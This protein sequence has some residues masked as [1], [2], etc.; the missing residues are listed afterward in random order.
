MET[1]NAGRPLIDAWIARSG[2]SAEAWLAQLFRVVVIPFYHL[3][4]R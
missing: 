1:D 2:L 3:L 4:C